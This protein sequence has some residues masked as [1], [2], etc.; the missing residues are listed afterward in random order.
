M[1][2]AAVRAPDIAS[3]EDLQIVYNWVDEIPLSRPKRNIARDFADGVLAAEIVNHFFPR[4]VEMHNYSAASSVDKKQYNW[5]TLNTKVLK[6]I[7]HQ[8]HPQ[9][10][11]DI[12]CAKPNAIEKVLRVLHDKVHRALRAG[13]V[14]GGRPGISEAPPLVAGRSTTPQKGAPPRGA[15]PIQR[16]D[17]ARARPSADDAH[18]G[19]T[20]S[21]PA[22]S[23]QQE[24]DTELLLEKEQTIAQMNE[25]V[26]IMQEKIKKLEQLVRI[27]DSKIEAMQQKLQKHGLM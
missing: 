12:T 24:V 3:D 4:L 18:V 27:K 15:T 20:A 2:A 10:V 17:E 9:D 14:G 8:I 5:Q 21:K 16:G 11:D 13:A 26:V 6:K 7:G 19:A 1:A 25:M 23:F 22:Q